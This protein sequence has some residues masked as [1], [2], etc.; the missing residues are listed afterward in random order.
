MEGVPRVSSLAFRTIF[1]GTKA[2]A[3][4]PLIEV[5]SAANG[6]LRLNVLFTNHAETLAAL[7][8]AGSMSAGLEAEIA[9]LVPLIVPFPLPLE[10]PPVPLAFACRRISELVGSAQP[11]T[12]VEAYVFLCRDSAEAILKALR[13]HSLVLIGTRGRWFLSR[14]Q[15]L[16][17]KLRAAGHQALLTSGV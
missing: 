5:P 6:R 1:E 3:L 8:S 15:R 13:P 10:D 14:S 17:R 12:N 7:K 4:E 2:S 9:L 16:A 11:N